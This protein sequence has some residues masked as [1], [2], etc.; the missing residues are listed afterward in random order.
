M[1][2]RSRAVLGGAE[3]PKITLSKALELY[4]DLPREKTLGKSTGQLRRW[5]NPRIKAIKNLIDVIGNKVVSEITGDDTLDFRDWWLDRIES[6]GHGPGTAN[7]GP[8]PVR[9]SC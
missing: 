3:E 6:E 5:R 8:V 1:I 7:N 2:I 4:W 9:C